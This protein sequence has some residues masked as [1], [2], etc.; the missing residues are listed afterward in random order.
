MGMEQEGLSEGTEESSLF[1]CLFLQSEWSQVKSYVK[2]YSH[3]TAPFFFSEAL[4]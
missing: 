2:T 3:L 4:L 1:L